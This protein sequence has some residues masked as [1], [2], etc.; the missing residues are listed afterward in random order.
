MYKL[1]FSAELLIMWRDQGCCSGIVHGTANLVALYTLHT[2][3]NEV[4]RAARSDTPLTRQSTQP[5]AI[6]GNVPL[7]QTAA[8][9]LTSA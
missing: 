3:R 1:A 2:G 7:G 4:T 5:W 8:H 9:T 6:K